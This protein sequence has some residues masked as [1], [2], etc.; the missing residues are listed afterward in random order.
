MIVRNMFF[1][2]LADTTLILVNADFPRQK[3][4]Q[5]TPFT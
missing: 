1:M 5:L 2:Q 3:K 4:N